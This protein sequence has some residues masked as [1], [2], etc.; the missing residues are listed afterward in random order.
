MA[1]PTY[2]KLFRPVLEMA[3]RQPITRT[4]ANEEMIRQFKLSPEDVNHKLASGSTSILNRTSWAM[5]FLS[6]ASLI[7]K[8]APKTYR[9][10]ARGL[11]VAGTS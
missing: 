5:T 11:R 8:Q 2:D 10:T 7:E 6:K 3:A 4:S 1:I 9:A